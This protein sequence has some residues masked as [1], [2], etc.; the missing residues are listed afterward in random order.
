MVKLRL[1]R[2][3]LLATGSVFRLVLVPGLPHRDYPG[4]GELDYG[5]P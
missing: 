3:H 1:V 2:L 5:F 4:S